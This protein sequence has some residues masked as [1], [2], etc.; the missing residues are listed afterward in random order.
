MGAPGASTAVA[1]RTAL[2]TSEVRVVVLDAKDDRRQIM[3]HVIELGGEDVKVVGFADNATSALEAVD[4]LHANAVLLEIQLPIAQGLAAIS[5]LRD[6]HPTLRIVVCSFHETAG[7]RQA[8]I[9]GGADAY[10]AKPVSPRAL[11]PLLRSP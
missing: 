8:A 2:P 6:A 1:D 3:R 4:R 5:A 10:L 9:A 11:R 7:T